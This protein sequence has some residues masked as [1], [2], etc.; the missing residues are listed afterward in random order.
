MDLMQKLTILT[1]GAKYD[2]ACTSSGTERP[3]NRGLGSTL[4]AGC[5]HSFS[6]DG[7]C[8]TLLKVLMTN[9]CIYDCRYCVNRRSNDIPRATFSP[10]ELADLTIE[11]YR[12]NYIE[13]LFLSSGVIKSPDQTMELLISVLSALRYKHDFWGYIHVKTIPGASSGLISRLG[14]L[15]DRISVNIELPSEES[16]KLLAPGKTKQS[17]LTPMTQIAQEIKSG[18]K[19]LAHYKNAPRFAPAGQA[20]QMIIGASPE[21][22]FQILK[23][24]SGLYGKFNLKRVFYS[25]YIPAVEDSLLP[26]PDT[27][28]PLLREHRFYQADWLMRYYKF[29]ANELLSEAAPNFNPYLDPKAGWAVNNLSEFPVDVNRAPLEVLL[30]IP[31]VGPT[32]ARRIVTARRTGALGFADLKRMGIVL[33]RAQFFIIAA[34]YTPPLRMNREATIRALIDPG[35]F[36]FGTEQLSFFG[37]GPLPLPGSGDVRS[38]DE[39]VKEAALCL[40]AGL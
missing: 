27:K 12:R 16:L 9:S 33:K 6:A 24:S 37:P 14:H 22:D 1:E 13:G 5:C 7:R 32:G 31:G 29:S 36:S 20:T 35:V 17:I 40:S 23:L 4:A 21:S 2:A 28:P 38:M 18:T 3:G 15:A 19:E 10:D 34:G 39:A 25:A 26:S 30:R 8:V 11:F